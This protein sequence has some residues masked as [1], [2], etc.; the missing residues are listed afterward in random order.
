MPLAQD[1]IILSKKQFEEIWSYSCAIN[2]RRLTEK[3]G[4]AQH[5]K[6]QMPEYFF[7]KEQFPIYCISLLEWLDKT[8][9]EH[10]FLE[11]NPVYLGILSNQKP[12]V[13]KRYLLNANKEFYA[14][15]DIRRIRGFSNDNQA[16]N[17]IKRHEYGVKLSKEDHNGIHEW[18]ISKKILDAEMKLERISEELPKLEAAIKNQIALH[19]SEMKKINQ[20]D[21]D[22]TLMLLGDKSEKYSMEIKKCQD[23]CKKG[24]NEDCEF[25][26]HRDTNKMRSGC[27]YVRAH[28]QN[29]LNQLSYFLTDTDKEDYIAFIRRQQFR[30]LINLEAKHKYACLQQPYMETIRTK[31]T[32]HGDEYI[33]CESEIELSK[34]DALLQKMWKDLKLDPPKPA[35][36]KT[37][38]DILTQQTGN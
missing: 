26:E 27:I 14:K 33:L 25:Y 18:V 21:E 38:D 3:V 6:T 4:L 22:K 13:F 16:T 1:E 5:H 19:M 37:L 12:E 17:W 8:F 9:G 28:I 11:Q 10:L 29:I 34:N 31:Q 35:S 24:V 20:I 30:V 23:D 2:G 15:K 7:D 32:K 36:K